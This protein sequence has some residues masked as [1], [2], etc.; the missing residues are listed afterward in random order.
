MDD[1]TGMTAQDLVWLMH[2]CGHT[3]SF[4]YREGATPAWFSEDEANDTRA[5]GDIDD[6]SLIRHVIEHCE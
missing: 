3:I 6:G 5:S 1:D 4:A 2:T